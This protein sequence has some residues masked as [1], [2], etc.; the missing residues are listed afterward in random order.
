M[1]LLAKEDS[2][3]GILLSPNTPRPDLTSEGI[4]LWNLA[5]RQ[6][7][8]CSDL[9]IITYSFQNN[10]ASASLSVSIV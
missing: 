5:S 10:C 2:V 4:M 9:I 1:T 8:L 7:E 3:H 6:T